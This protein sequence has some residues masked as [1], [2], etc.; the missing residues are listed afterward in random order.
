MV[1]SKA[2]ALLINEY[3]WKSYNQIFVNNH[4]KVLNFLSANPNL[5]CL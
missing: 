2:V 3:I 5:E 4:C 1:Y